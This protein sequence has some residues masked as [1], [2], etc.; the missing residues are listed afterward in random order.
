MACQEQV[1]AMTVEIATALG[2]G[3]GASK[4][5]IINDEGLLPQP[6]DNPDTMTWKVSKIKEILGDNAND[7]INSMG[8]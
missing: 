7:V 2:G 4:F 5:K 6:S 1:K 8:T 3:S